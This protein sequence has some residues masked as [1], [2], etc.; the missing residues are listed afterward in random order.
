MHHAQ[1]HTITSVE[2]QPERWVEVDWD[3]E[4]GLDFTVPVDV[5]VSNQR[6][7]LGRVAAAIAASSA[8][9]ENVQVI[10]RERGRSSLRF[11]IRV[12]NR[13]H[14]ADV[15]RGIRNTQQV[16]RVTRVKG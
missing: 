8:D 7:V 12:R 14:L 4:T 16:K 5:Q 9:I 13:L 10:D 1:C 15:F 3:E 6:G 11:T 2:N